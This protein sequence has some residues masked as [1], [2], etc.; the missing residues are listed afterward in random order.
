M[1]D[2]NVLVENLQKAMSVEDISFARKTAFWPSS[3]RSV[4]MG[5]RLGAANQISLSYT[6]PDPLS[7][8]Y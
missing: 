3:H 5:G 4:G 6:I 1:A 7:S 8:D 2:L